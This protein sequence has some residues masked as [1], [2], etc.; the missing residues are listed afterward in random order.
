MYSSIKCVNVDWK[1]LDNK[2]KVEVTGMEKLIFNKILGFKIVYS[3]IVMIQIQEFQLTLHDIYAKNMFIS[4]LFKV[5]VI[6]KNKIDYITMNSKTS[7]I[8]R[9]RK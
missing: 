5:A 1:I 7:L 3:R 4:E 9:A 2:F 8:L 6:I